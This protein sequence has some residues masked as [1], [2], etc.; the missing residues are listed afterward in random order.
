MWKLQN[1]LY[2]FIK[3]KCWINKGS[4]IERK[5]KQ[6]NQQ[7]WIQIEF[8]SFINQ[9]TIQNVAKPCMYY[10]ELFHFAD[11]YSLY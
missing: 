11:V 6:E 7:Y 1:K 5:K 8:D 4:N 10:D 3:L 9:L 2:K